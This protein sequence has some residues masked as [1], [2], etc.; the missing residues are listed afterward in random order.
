MSYEKKS[1]LEFK[2]KLQRQELLHIREKIIIS[3]FLRD[4]AMRKFSAFP[5][6]AYRVIQEG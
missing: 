4:Q 3:V 5:Q 2:R 1:R 6:K